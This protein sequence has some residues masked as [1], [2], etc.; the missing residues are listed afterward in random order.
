MRIRFA[1]FADIRSILALERLSPTAG[2]WSEEQYRQALG[3]D[4]PERLVLVAEEVAAE[5]STRLAGQGGQDSGFA[6]GGFL[7][8]RHVA[9]EWELENIVV[10]AS[11]RRKGTGTRLLNCLLAAARETNS[12]WLLLEV[13]ESNAPARSFYEK[14]GFE[15]TGRRKLY[16]AEPAEDAVLYRR[17]VPAAGKSEL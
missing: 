12:E 16:Y 10:L 15:Q 11:S 13:R 1:T 6:L 8:A 14:A 4:G 2:H 9:A 17:R 7:V 3:R 5:E